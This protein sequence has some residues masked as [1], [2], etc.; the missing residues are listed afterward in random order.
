MATVNTPR[1]SDLIY[2]HLGANEQ[3]I[4]DKVKIP[5]LRRLAIHTVALK[6]KLQFTGWLQYLM[7]VPATFAL[8]LFAGFVYLIGFHS[9]ATWLVWL[10][11]LLS[12]IILFDVI[13]CRF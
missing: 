3:A 6:M 4:I 5:W 10:P 2:K 12:A 1:K 11:L 8:F 9:T 13:T 7:P